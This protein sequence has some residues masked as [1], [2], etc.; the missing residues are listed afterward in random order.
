MNRMFNYPYLF[1][2]YL[3]EIS[4][5][6]YNNAHKLH[7][8]KIDRIILECIT[9]SQDCIFNYC[10]LPKLNSKMVMIMNRIW[11]TNNNQ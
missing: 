4:T 3:I 9:N 11:S 5:N 8:F 7:L 2:H 10:T 1:H 6:N